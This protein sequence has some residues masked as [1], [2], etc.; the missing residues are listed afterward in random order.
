MRNYPNV[1]LRCHSMS[2]CQVYD[3]AY[4]DKG[5]LLARKRRI[6][7]ENDL[8][9]RKTIFVGH[10]ATIVGRRRSNFRRDIF[11]PNRRDASCDGY[12]K[13]LSHRCTEFYRSLMQF[14][15]GLIGAAVCGTDIYHYIDFYYDRLYAPNFDA[16]SQ[17]LFYRLHE[18]WRVISS[19]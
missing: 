9:P 7:R 4:A 6:T 11:L 8:R 13:S 15:S 5:K 19:K 18:A 16:S 2:I 12:S 14:S 10:A 3:V 17:L 1:L